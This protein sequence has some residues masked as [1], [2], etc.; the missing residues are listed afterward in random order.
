MSAATA[1][2]IGCTDLARAGRGYHCRA[3]DEPLKGNSFMNVKACAPC[4]EAA[5]RLAKTVRIL[6]AYEECD[7]LS[8]HTNTSDC[9]L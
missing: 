3:W 7:A 4:M 9:N 8:R 5:C 1:V 6:D 2:C